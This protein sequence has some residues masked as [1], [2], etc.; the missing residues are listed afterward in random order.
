LG[1]A[2]NYAL[3]RW[4]KLK[5]FTDH[6]FLEMDTN[7]VENSIRPHAITRKNCLFAGSEEV[8]ETAAIHA[9][10]VN[11]CKRLGI[12]PFDY[13]KDVL[14]KLGR[15]QYSDIDELLPDRLKASQLAQR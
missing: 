13:I 12:N 8:G 9:T 3:E 11:T 15:K 5:R 1:I 6:G 2:V 14:I 4:H 7:F 10:I